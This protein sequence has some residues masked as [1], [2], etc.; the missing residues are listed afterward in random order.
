M[1]V[2]SYRSAGISEIDLICPLWEQLNEFHHAKANRFRSHYEQ[3]TFDDRKSYFRKL[4]ET[5]QIRLDFAADTMTG[6]YVGYC[7]SSVSAE[8]TGEVESL[9]VEA[10]YRSEGIGTILVARALAWMDSLDTVRKRVSVGDGNEAA[11]AFYRKFGFYPR[12][13]VLEQKTDEVCHI[14]DPKPVN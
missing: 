1:H 2:V 10:A 6:M 5:G 11:W 14:P 9:F 12:M 4:H 13:T 8:D 7:V 3:M